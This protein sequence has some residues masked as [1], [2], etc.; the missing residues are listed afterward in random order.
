MEVMECAGLGSRSPAAAMIS[1]VATTGRPPVRPLAG[2]GQAL[3]GPGD[4]ELADELS[5]SAAKTWNTRS[6]GPPPVPQR[7]GG[8]GRHSVTTVGL[9]GCGS[10]VPI[11]R[12]LERRA[13]GRFSMVRYSTIGIVKHSSFSALCARKI[14]NV[15]HFAC[16]SGRMPSPSDV[17]LPDGP[18]VGLLSCPEA[19]M[20]G[21]Q[22][23]RY[24]G[25]GRVDRSRTPGS[26]VRKGAHLKVPARPV[27]QVLSGP[28]PDLRRIPP[29]DHPT[30]PAAEMRGI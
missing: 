4:D 26:S 1:G 11:G 17:R 7:R 6:P 13:S 30:R 29:V 3:A 16:P 25:T 18:I 9:R 12:S 19:E 15:R 24:S 8:V 23:L 28:V 21:G 10:A 27:V 14:G 2:G 20:R 22:P 5:A